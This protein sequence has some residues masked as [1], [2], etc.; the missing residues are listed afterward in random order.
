[1]AKEN[2]SGKDSSKEGEASGDAEIED[3]MQRSQTMVTDEEGGIRVDDEIYIPPPLKT[4]SEVDTS[5]PRLM[6]TKIVNEN[7]KSYGGVQVIGPFHKSFSAIVGPNGSGK[8]NVIDAMLFV[9]G[10]RA[11]KI[12]SKKISVLIHN[13]SQLQNVNSC[14]VSVHFQQIIDNPQSD[15]DVVPNSEFVISRTAFKDN[16]SYYELNK[17][18]VQFKE[19][20]K[21]LR[22]YGVDLDHNRFLILQGEVEQ[23]AMMKPKAQNENDTGMLEYLEDIIG[24]FR[25]KE[26]LEKLSQNVELLTEYRMEKLN[27]LR[28]VEKE[29]AALEEPMQ[30]AVE[31]LQLENTVT[32]LQHQEYCYK[33]FET[34]NEVT[35]QENTMNNLNEGLS[36]LMTKMNEIAN[37]KEAK[38][39]VINEKNKKWDHLQKQKDEVV[40]KFDKIRKHD[41][42]LHAELIETNKRR[43]ANIASLKTEKSKLEELRKVPE[44]SA[45]DIEECNELIEKQEKSKKKEE[46]ILETLMTEIRKKT[47]PL[48]NERSQFEKQL[49]D[50]RKDVD[51]AQAAVNIAQ[52]ELELYTSVESTEKEKLEKLKNSLNATTENLEE[53][54]QQLQCLENDIPSTQ[55]ELGQAQKELETVKAREIEITSKL[56]SMRLSF[57]E[58]KSAMQA[59]TSR[60]RII[61]SL[62]REKR[63][64]RLPGVFGRLGDLGAIDA[65]YDVAIST[66]CGPLDNIVVDTVATAQKCITFLRQN[67][68]GRATFI[69]LEK[70]QHLLSRCKQKIQTPENASRL[71]DLIRV[72]D[73][74][75]LPAFYYG[76]QDTLVVNDL[77]QATRIA[78][79]QRRFRVVTLKGE[80]IEL[81]GTMSGGG[82]TALRGRMG[83]KLVKNDLSAADF[84]KLQSHLNKTN[85]ECNQLRARSQ[86]LENQ[87]HTLTV[88]L[89]NMKVNQEKLQIEVNTLEE[90]KPSLLTQLKIQEKKAKDSVSDPKKVEQLKKALDA[91][92]KTFEKVKENSTGVEKQVKSI[93]DKIE[94]L[95]G[96]K[97]K[98]QQKQI[99]SITKSIDSTKAEICRLQVAIKTAER[100]VKKIEQRIESLEN[101]VVTCVERLREIEKEKHEL[102]E[103]GKEYLKELDELTEALSERDEATKSLKEELNALQ[104][105]ENKLK[106]VKIDL[107]QKMKEC[108]SVIKELKHRIPE[109]TKRIAQLQ[110]QAIPGENPEELKELTEEELSKIDEKVLSNNLQ[111][112]K[113]RLPTEI[114]N[115]QLINE[116]REKDALYLKRAAD[117]EQITTKRNRIRDI[118]ETVRRRRIEEFLAGFTVIT[119]KLKE[120]YQ[121][122]TLGGDAELE[123][124]DSLDPFSEGIAFSV[125][126]PKK[127]WKNICN[128]SGGEKTL[129][130]LALVFALHHYKPTPLYFMDEID[131]A[132]DFKNVSIVGN[133]IKE[134]TKNAQFIVI[135]LRSNMFELADYLVG[136]YKT[137]NCTKS[138]TVDLK[139]YYDKNG[140]APPTQIT[141]KS[142]YS[143]QVQKF[144]QHHKDNATR[145]AN[146]VQVAD[147]N[148]EM[149][150]ND[151]LQLPELGLCPTPKK[152]VH[153]D[154]K[155]DSTSSK[156]D[157]DI[158]KQPLRKKR[159]T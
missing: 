159:R 42:S 158:S 130:S 23:I 27:R 88:N 143:S 94:S 95:S 118:Y 11:T 92:K 153:N 148:R 121:M 58:Q 13:S 123:L 28:I 156:S 125:R 4:I 20:G 145:N 64:G 67:D 35:Q 2:G 115:M 77:D 151:P 80:L 84:E 135:S 6:I 66:A 96:A 3:F 50:L 41:E 8:S 65:K 100:N 107:D 79:G 7:F 17:K 124:V 99:T 34:I 142:M 1:M 57:E 113:K 149:N 70:Q 10:Y 89:K 32:K 75:I 112:A 138:C 140:I 97:V 104:T 24:T 12:R 54:K 61:S 9:F 136:I 120:M 139:K 81:S 21:L 71:F 63:E 40:A 126:P 39:K 16:S 134:R 18:K 74:R 68:I 33:R 114:P 106:A 109:L 150:G 83:Q 154:P 56:K 43:K 31:Y 22:S 30:E 87:I 86:F 82:R 93:N 146:N 48:L 25:Y 132:L 103:K 29:K 72:D 19:I 26:P 38:M 157:N 141:S 55:R 117:L 73:E 111:K 60:N 53:R 116:Y 52:S 91:A 69:P 59:N 90:Q 85:E 119:D 5:G 105:T 128:L 102:E 127:S 44:K 147:E 129:S 15:Y 45:K 76:L 62:M 14:T 155:R 152:V 110:L 51:Q 122:I 133:Y 101:D 78:Y 131:A 108:K 36:N 144:S 47:E 98:T 49:I 46:A 37:E 137:Y